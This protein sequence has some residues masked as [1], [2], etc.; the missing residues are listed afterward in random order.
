MKRLFKITGVSQECWIIF[1]YFK[2]LVHIGEWGPYQK[3]L[4]FMLCIPAC[5]PAAFIAFNQ[6]GIKII[7]R[8]QRQCWALIPFNFD[9]IEVLKVGLIWLTGQSIKSFL[10]WTTLI[11]QDFLSAGFPVPRA[12]PLVQSARLTSG[13]SG[14]Q[15]DSETSPGVTPGERGRRPEA[16]QQV[17]DVQG[18][19]DRGVPGQRRDVAAPPQHQ[20]A[21]GGLSEWLELRHWGVCQY[22]RHRA[23]PR[24]Q[25]PVVALN[26]H[27]SLLCWKSYRKY[28]V[29][30]NSWQVC[31]VY[32]ENGRFNVLP[33]TAGGLHSSWCWRWPSVWALL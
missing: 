9:L 29:W 13:R 27:C 32:E 1:L 17:Y 24:L 11:S 7:L 15:L 22:T 10:L 6:V 14:A 28:F 31:P 2:V 16:V 26:I 21:S 33:G 30:T 25:Q 12:Q 19:L 4:F 23:G 18:Q 3:F 5:L 8:L 20:L